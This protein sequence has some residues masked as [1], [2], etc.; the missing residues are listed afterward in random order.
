MAKRW[1]TLRLDDETIRHAKVIAAARDV[2]LRRF[3]AAQVESIVEDDAR[4]EVAHRRY[5]DLTRRVSGSS[6]G[7][8]MDRSELHGR[9]SADGS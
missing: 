5:L 9:G 1:V 8:K 3:L 7:R 6:R 2:S 4:Y